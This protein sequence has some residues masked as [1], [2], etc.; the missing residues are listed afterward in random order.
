MTVAEENLIEDDQLSDDEDLGLF[1]TK[2]Q[3]KPLPI[4]E[5]ILPCITKVQ[6]LSCFFKKWVC[7]WGDLIDQSLSE[8]KVAFCV[9]HTTVHL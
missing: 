3:N 7:I 5:I 4:I 6:R 8:A 9:S 1:F 2:S